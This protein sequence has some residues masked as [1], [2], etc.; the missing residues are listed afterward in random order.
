MRQIATTSFLTG[1]MFFVWDFAYSEEQVKPTLAIGALI[2]VEVSKGDNFDKVRSG[3]VVLATVEIAIDSQINNLVSGHIS[4]LHEEDDTPLE[5]DEATIKIQKKDSPFGIIV[6]QM[7]VPFGLFESAMISD[8]L[9]LELGEARE[10]ALVI[11]YTNNFYVSAYLYNG[12]SKKASRDDRL[13][14]SGAVG[15]NFESE[16][17]S[18]DVGYSAI[19]SIADSENITEAIEE[20]G[21]TTPDALTELVDG[22][23]AYAVVKS[24][25]VILIAEVVRANGK[26]NTADVSVGASG[27]MKATNLEAVL[28]ISSGVVLAAASQSTNNLAG[29]LPKKRR[30]VS[31]HYEFAK[32]TTLGFEY[33]RDEDYSVSGGGTGNSSHTVTMQLAVRW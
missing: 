11:S 19:S 3:D 21:L 27:K 22:S 23:A 33:L 10:S 7:Y 8:P 12:D 2:E 1:I 4:L 6:G 16:S 17:L 24:G 15:Y 20:E 31:A 25:A 28:Q 18:F 29:Y 14:Q 13:D 30:M 26:F 9:T 32:N 5:V